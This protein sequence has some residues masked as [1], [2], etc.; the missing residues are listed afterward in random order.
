MQEIV[1]LRGRVAAAA[2]VL[3]LRKHLERLREAELAAVERRFA[4]EG[5]RARHDES[6]RRDRQEVPRCEAIAAAIEAPLA[7]NAIAGELLEEGFRWTHRPALLFASQEVLGDLRSEERRVGK[8]CR[9][10]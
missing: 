9:S 8:E 6:G 10:R 5:Q 4:A 3:R 2:G 1:Q 7:V